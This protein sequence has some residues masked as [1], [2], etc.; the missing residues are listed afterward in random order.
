MRT[1]RMRG[2]VIC[3]RIAGRSRARTK[4]QS[5]W[6]R[7]PASPQALHCAGIFGLALTKDVCILEVCSMGLLLTVLPCISFILARCL[8][9]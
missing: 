2:Q 9:F 4:C 6:P 8:R 3:L 5:V 1:L 7:A